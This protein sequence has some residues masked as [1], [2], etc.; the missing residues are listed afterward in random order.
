MVYDLRLSD[1]IQPEEGDEELDDGS[2][3]STAVGYILGDRGG[4]GGEGCDGDR[5][6][7]AVV[8]VRGE[9]DGK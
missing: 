8:V 3:E 9:K 7:P 1:E 5:F 6:L 2:K 4:G